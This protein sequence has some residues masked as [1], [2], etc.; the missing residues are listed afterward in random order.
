MDRV[1]PAGRK[2]PAGLAVAV[3]LRLG[4]GYRGGGGLLDQSERGAQCQES[5]DDGVPE[6]NELV[7]G[8]V[9]SLSGRAICVLSS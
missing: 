7:P 5:R 9:P 3:A 8:H 6:L 2:D 4:L 1:H